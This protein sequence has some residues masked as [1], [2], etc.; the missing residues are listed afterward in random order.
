MKRDIESL[1]D[2]K[3]IDSINVSK[4]WRLWEIIGL[5]NDVEQKMVSMK[6]RITR[7]IRRRD[8]ET[9]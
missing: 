7:E 3:I 1:V 5:C 8:Y 9:S 4:K 2:I 6:Y